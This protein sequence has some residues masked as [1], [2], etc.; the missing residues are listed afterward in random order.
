MVE[1]Q[2]LFDSVINSRWFENST[3]C[4]FTS[5]PSIVFRLTLC[6][7]SPSLADRLL[8]QGPSFSLFPFLSLLPADM[9]PLCSL[10]T[11]LVR[12][13]LVKEPLQDYFPE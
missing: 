5:S 4:S 13:K 1:A 2:I 12:E 11:D 3:V 10:K 8:Q 7:I 6:L 9:S